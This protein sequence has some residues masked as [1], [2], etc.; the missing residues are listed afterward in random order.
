MESGDV[1]GVNRGAF[2]VGLLLALVAVSLV[3]LN[4]ATRD[5]DK[6]G[7]LYPT[8]L[9]ISGAELVMLFLLIGANLHRLVRQYRNRATG[10]RLSVRLIVMFVILAVVPV[11][12]VYYFSLEFLQR[13]I[14]NWFDVRVD[15]ALNSSLKLSRAAL[16][17]KMREQMRAAERMATELTG[18]PNSQAPFVLDEMLQRS[19]ASELTLLTFSG[20]IIASSSI[21]PTVIIPNQPHETVLLQVRQGHKYVSLDPAGDSGL[22]IRVVVAVPH[23]DAATEARALQLLMPVPERISQ[24][25]NEVQAGYLQYEELS[26][27]REPL[28]F[29]FVLTLSLVLVLTLFTAVW[30]AFYSARRL[31][32]PIRVLAIGTR[33]VSAGDY[34]K[35]LPLPSN[36]ELGVLVKSFNDM[37]QKIAEASNEAQQS[38]Q[39]AEEQRTYLEAVLG[40]LSSGVLV[41]DRNFNLRMAN[42]VAGQILGFDLEARVG[43]N[44]TRLAEENVVVRHLVDAIREHLESSREEW[45]Q[46][47]TLFGKGG[48][49]IL[50]CRGATLPDISETRGEHVIVY[51]DITTL[52]RAQR[53]AA[54]GEVARRLAHEIKNPLTPIQLSAERLRHKYLA[55]MNETDAAVLNRATHTIVQQVE[56]MKEMVKAFSE[57]ARTPRLALEQLDLNRLVEEVLDLYHSEEG[58]VDIVTRLE[59]GLP[60]IE[61]DPGRIR[62]LLH[63]LIKNALEATEQQGQQ[64]V[65][66]TTRT[67][68]E[69]GYKVV[70]LAV[71]DNGPGIPEAMLRDLFEPYITTKPKGSGLGMAIVKK[72][73][74]EH[75]G[76]ISAENRPGSGACVIVRF[77]VEANASGG[78]EQR[79]MASQNGSPFLPG[80]T[81]ARSEQR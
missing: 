13:G 80:A 52:V 43:T 69:A 19:E 75:G 27:M 73:V 47:V 45:R 59:D 24:L 2:A 34:G 62:Q 79:T 16:D 4:V 17:E 55:T 49:Q 41:V 68:E 33:L 18:T 11:S 9:I 8:L 10:S 37:T 60:H 22:L 51:D 14:D 15:S 77:P 72:I 42:A 66:V 6:F 74:E 70:E 57:Y 81:R 67:L 38:K 35:R 61:A 12:V 28:K 39:Q 40:R 7:R 56:V 25:A 20:R 65:T 23:V 71:E 53:D 26:Y 44:I 1:K 29:S 21:N 63:N 54:W 5:P 30:A 32:A 76:I 31:V 50:M 46:E 48:R 36:D 64:R 3:L 78:E 58:K